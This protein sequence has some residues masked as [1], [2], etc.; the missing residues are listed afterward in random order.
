MRVSRQQKQIL[1]VLHTN[2]RPLRLVEIIDFVKKKRWESKS[3]SDKAKFSHPRVLS[4]SFCRSMKTLRVKGLVINVSERGSPRW[5]LTEQGI[6]KAKE[7]NGE[8][9]RQIE[10]N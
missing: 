5:V 4:A 3:S 1:L 2:P 10:K 6:A 9:K 7:I 8:L